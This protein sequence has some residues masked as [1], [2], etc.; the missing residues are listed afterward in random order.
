MNVVCALSR[1]GD[2]SSLIAQNLR[3]QNEPYKVFQEAYPY[4]IARAVRKFKH[5]TTLADKHE[6]VI[7]CAESL[8]LS[9]GILS[10]ALAAHAGR[11]NIVEIAK[12]EESVQ[13]GGVS[14]GHWVAVIRAVG[15]GSRESGDKAAGLAEATALKKGG[16][17]LM[18][19][20]DA[21]VTLRNKI[22][23]GAGPRTRA[24][25]EKSLEKLE[26]LVF[27]SLSSSAFLARSQ[28]VHMDRLRWL[29][30]IGRFQISGLSLMGDH[31]DFE[32]VDFATDRPLADNGLYV[33]TQQ[34]ETIPLSPYCILNDCPACLAPELYYPDRLTNSTA[35]LKS[36]DRGHELESEMVFKHLVSMS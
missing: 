4:A 34:G 11:K 36:L 17:G 19:D 33:F 13:Q 12:W 7:Q 31:P 24:E 9:L 15:S 18:A 3:K 1:L 26:E 29:P 30:D 35:L 25:I 22:R 5:G 2:L 23:H 21:L 28:W 32:P 27:N 8:I 6:A 14:L 20:L 16:K 10:L